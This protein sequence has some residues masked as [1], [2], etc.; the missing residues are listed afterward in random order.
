M[1][2]TVLG[3]SPQ[4]LAHLFQA[5]NQLGRERSPIEGHGIDLS[6]ARELVQLIAEGRID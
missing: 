1:R 3:M 2:D 6:L 4:Q 5:F